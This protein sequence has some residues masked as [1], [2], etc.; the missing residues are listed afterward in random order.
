M[1]AMLF[2]FTTAAVLSS[3]GDGPTVTSCSWKSASGTYD[4][5]VTDAAHWT[6]GHTPNAKELAEFGQNANYTV[7]MPDDGW[8][9][10]SSLK[11]GAMAGYSLSISTLG[12]YLHQ[13]SSAEDNYAA[14]SFQVYADD[15]I[16]VRLITSDYD[17]SQSRIENAL[18]TVKS[19]TADS[20]E[21][22]HSF[23]VTGGSFNLLDPAGTTSDNLNDMRL[24]MGATTPDAHIA[25]SSSTVRLPTVSFHGAQ[26][27][28]AE[29][30]F[31]EC[32]VTLGGQ[33][34]SC[35]NNR[36]GPAT[37]LV[38]FANG[39]KAVLTGGLYLDNSNTG[40]RMTKAMRLVAEGE[41]TTVDIAS[42]NSNSGI[43]YSGN[44]DN[45][46]YL[47][48]NDGAAVS[49]AGGSA[50]HFAQALANGNPLPKARAELTVTDATMTFGSES[51]PAKEIT[52][53]Q[54]YDA[55]GTLTV[56]GDSIVNIYAGSNQ[57]FGYNN[58]DFMPSEG[59]LNVTGG[60]VTFHEGNS[61]R[62]YLG[63][64]AA[65]T[66]RL[67][68]SDGRLVVEGGYGL[69]VHKGVGYITVSGG[70]MDVSRLPICSEESSAAESVV[71][72][73]GGIIT[74][75]PRTENTKSLTD[76]KGVQITTN[77]KTTRRARLVLNGGVMN[78]NYVIGGSSAQL[79][80]GTGFAAFEANGGTL[81]ANAAAPFLLET[82]DEAKLGPKGLTIES[83]YA[84]TIR[85][86]FSDA[87]SGQGKLILKGIGVKTMS[88]ATMV[89]EIVVEGG[90]VSFDADACPK[91]HVTVKDGALV[92]FNG[93]AANGDLTGLS[94]GDDSSFARLVV[95]EG[96]SFSVSGDVSIKNV[97]LELSGD[98]ALDSTNTIFRC[99]GTISDDSVEA[100]QKSLI[101]SGLSS[102]QAGE[103]LAQTKDGETVLSLVVRKSKDVILRVDEGVS[104]VVESVIV[105]PGD[106]LR[107][108][109]GETARL[110]VSGPLKCE[111]L[112]KEGCGA[113]SL[114]A[115]DNETRSTI[116]VQ[117]GMLSATS[118][119]AF[120]WHDTIFPGL[121]TLGSATLAIA[122]P[123]DEAEFPWTVTM[124]AESDDGACVVKT[125]SAV[126]FRHLALG[127][128]CFIKRGA[129]RL[130]LD[131]PSGT[132]TFSSSAG[133]N[134]ANNTVSAETVTF[135]E[136]GQPPQE[137][138]AG[139]TV[140]E[141]E[142]RLTGDASYQVSSERTP[143]VTYIGI[144]VKGIE[145]EPGIVVDGTTAV[146]SRE[147]SRHFHLGCG[148]T[149]TNSDVRRPYLV[150]TNGATV[151][152]TSFVTGRNS[153]GSVA[154]YVYFDASTLNV[155]EYLYTLEGGTEGETPTYSFVNGSRLHVDK[156]GQHGIW[157]QGNDTTIVFDNSF[158]ACDANNTRA[159]IVVKNGT[160]LMEFR[161]GS[162]LYAD[163]F[164]QKNDNQKLTLSF[165]G[166]EWNPSD[167]NYELTATYPEQLVLV[168]GKGGLLLAPPADATWTISGATVV[169]D[170]GAVVVR[171]D[172]TVVFG[173][174]VAKP[175]VRLK[176]TGTVSGYL[177]SPVLA[178]PLRDD[179]TL[180]EILCFEDVSLT[181]R[182]SVDLENTAEQL[183]KH[184]RSNVVV[185]RFKGTA[186]D[187][188]TWKV[189]GSEFGSLFRIVDDKVVANIGTSGITIII[190]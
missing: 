142:L 141:G 67:T 80:G 23:T 2:V 53:G 136:G 63:Y 38:R 189:I 167:G 102:D 58:N 117:S 173:E 68:V 184:L 101:S 183:S 6:L 59:I 33:L 185:A 109:V 98:Y 159:Q 51:S 175:G 74:V 132:V 83:D 46:L 119:A 149:D 48:V 111:S 180:D 182:V 28:V 8:T 138:Y 61:Y 20:E 95:A 64:G 79:N 11:F 118:V 170:D 49:F 43:S 4:G 32:L 127:K 116:A 55:L 25:Y 21:P 131:A 160:G 45:T 85:Q 18:M 26:T 47:D 37:N 52:Y 30:S 70:E 13:D 125:D 73:T 34:K 124:A 103:C 168:A 24:F 146:F 181:G 145:S 65:T 126:T 122:D 154:P 77:G 97:H 172:G 165:D 99:T 112:V 110:T 171:G 178:A 1:K 161:N 137:N 69:G 114:T 44:W 56:A 153:S 100:W 91:S 19:A 123:E 15:K 176:G 144:P 27:G 5:V 62:L 143:G 31:N 42:G 41:G 54:G 129:G 81:K 107:M 7:F 174:N 17:A 108:I 82:F 89:S 36:V 60:T 9:T 50:W 22:Y 190:R 157:F 158:L 121:L 66:G 169:A 94:L 140:S 150:A 12:S 152:V 84:A 39:S 156:S 87:D 187:V 88:G 155:S 139:L 134:E 16:L 164:I 3:W 133:K 104:N 106:T 105:P 113:A 130:T 93:G 179:G 71:Q 40:G 14:Q 147:G 115:T 188:S 72:Q 96:E 29:L 128:G 162:V 86:A 78:A 76:M 151:N 92:N 75:T 90:E 35:D 163:H 120:G 186:P 148:I 166:G 57:F 177:H 10:L 135:A